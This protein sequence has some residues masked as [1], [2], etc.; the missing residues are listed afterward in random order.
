MSIEKLLTGL[1]KG[2]NCHKIGGKKRM[3]KK[4]KNLEATTVIANRKKEKEAKKNKA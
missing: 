4:L 3:N 2:M 1:K